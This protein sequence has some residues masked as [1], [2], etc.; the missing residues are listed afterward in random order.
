MN[1]SDWP[2]GV[3]GEQQVLH[4]WKSSNQPSKIIAQREIV[5]LA[6]VVS[7]F[8]KRADCLA[9]SKPCALKPMTLS[10][11]NWSLVC[12]SQSHFKSCVGPWRAGRSAALLTKSL[13]P[14]HLCG[15]NLIRRRG[16]HNRLSKRCFKGER[17]G[18]V[19]CLCLQQTCK[20]SLQGSC[21]QPN[22]RVS[23]TPFELLP[24][25]WDVHM[26]SRAGPGRNT[27]E[28]AW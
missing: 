18:D 9:L 23:R 26:Q 8:C 13:L 11:S 16:G 15:E 1:H 4:C 28:V 5:G 27:R 7:G 2:A 17:P 24:W 10:N 20:K 19:Q 25:H 3:A 21:I 12:Y 14:I 22:P 6:E